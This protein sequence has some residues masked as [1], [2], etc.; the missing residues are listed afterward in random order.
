MPAPSKFSYKEVEIFLPD[1]LSLLVLFSGWL[2]VLYV[3]CDFD[4]QE[5]KVEI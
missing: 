4:L 5:M 1:S 2:Y 3:L